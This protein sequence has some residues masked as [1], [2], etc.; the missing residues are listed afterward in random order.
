MV[1]P[2]CATL[3]DSPLGDVNLIDKCIEDKIVKL[4]FMGER[5]H[6]LQSHDAT[7]LLHY[8]FAI[9]RVLHLLQTSP[10]FLF[11]AWHDYDLHV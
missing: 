1:N 4:R 2:D 9:P 3:L 5:L 10:S 6:Q 8:S 7:T 11:S